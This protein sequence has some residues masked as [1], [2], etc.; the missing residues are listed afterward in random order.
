MEVI[1]SMDDANRVAS[2]CER[3][4][5]SYDATFVRLR[6]NSGSRR[7]T[8]WRGVQISTGR[9]FANK[10][11]MFGDDKRDDETSESITINDI[12]S[13]VSFSGSLFTYY[14]IT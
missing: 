13:K 10:I 5:S 3:C 6:R 4:G 2:R 9:R 11:E 1:E 7:T 8:D 14:P 12:K